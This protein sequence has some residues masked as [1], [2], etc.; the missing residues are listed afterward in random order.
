MPKTAPE[1]PPK[2]K[3]PPVALINAAAFKWGCKLDGSVTFQL[4]IA[5]SNVKGCTAKLDPDL[6][7]ME[8]VLEAYQDFS[9]VFSKAKASTLAP[10]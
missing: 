7:D 10:H 9:D 4:N 3:G 2:L 1:P 8:N 6:M 5:S